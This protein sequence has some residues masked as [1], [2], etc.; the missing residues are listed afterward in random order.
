[1]DGKTIVSVRLPDDV[2]LGIDEKVFERR[3]RRERGRAASRTGVIVEL[4]A[5]AV[6]KPGAKRN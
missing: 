1:V 3:K 5:A 6:L 2:L 4:L